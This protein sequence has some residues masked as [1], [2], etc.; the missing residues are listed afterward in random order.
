MN[1][2]SRLFHSFQDGV[3]FTAFDTETTGLYCN[4]DHVIEIGAVKFNVNGII[5]T[6]N[7]LINPHVEIPY[8][9]TKING[10]NNTMVCKEPDF[11]TIYPKFSEFISGTTLIAHNSNFDIGF[12]NSELRRI[13]KPCLCAPSVPAIDTIKLAKHVYPLMGKYNLQFLATKF[14]IN[15]ENAHRAQDDA[16][17]CMEVFLH[18]LK[19]LEK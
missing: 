13:Q 11:L 18:C 15:V 2:F 4:E 16:R 17:V 5:D 9:A 6:Y 7:T 14:S 10:I 8:Q 3:T 12:I 19:E 1:E